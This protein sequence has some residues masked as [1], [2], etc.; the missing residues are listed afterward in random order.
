MTFTD[1]LTASAIILAVV[2]IGS[3]VLFF[4]V[5]TDRAAKS[6][7]EISDY[8]G[9]MREVLGKI[10]GLTTSTREEVW[11][12]FKLLLEKV[13]G[14]ERASIGQE[15]EERVAAIEQRVVGVE[16]RSQA[17]GDE[18]LGTM[19][20][21]LKRDV[22]SL[23]RDLVGLRESRASA[24]AD[25]GLGG[26]LGN[27]YLGRGG[28]PE[29]VLVSIDPQ[30]IAPGGNVRIDIRTFGGLVLGV[31]IPG[32]RTAC[33]VLTPDGRTLVARLAPLGFGEESAVFPDDFPYGSS[34]AE[35]EYL[36]TVYR[37]GAGVS[38]AGEESKAVFRGSF[39][40]RSGGAE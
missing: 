40:V 23:Q 7:R 39:Y 38:V 6:Q 4:I 16:D 28:P 37:R 33:E 17:A 12:Q 3:E 24:G 1:G 22:T 15:L 20:G 36:V 32:A 25:L 18:E 27:I 19:V 30:T 13:V 8:V 11:E 14:Q 29:T 35:G 5:Q 2:A 21:E 31:Y 9:Q 34:Q 10:E 26:T